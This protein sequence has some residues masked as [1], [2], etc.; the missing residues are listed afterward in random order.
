MTPDVL[1][2]ASFSNY[3]LMASLVSHISLYSFSV[4]NIVFKSLGLD[5]I[6]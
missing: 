5:E 1:L 4:A 3:Q 2:S 6:T